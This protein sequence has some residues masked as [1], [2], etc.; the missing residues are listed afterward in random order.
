M[1]S[2]GRHAQSAVKSTLPSHAASVRSARQDG[3]QH[4]PFLNFVAVTKA[5]LVTVLYFHTRPQAQPVV[6]L[7][8][9]PPRGSYLQPAHIPIC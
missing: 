9:S 7:T 5:W 2:T 8:I 6:G 3:Q 4:F 1:Q